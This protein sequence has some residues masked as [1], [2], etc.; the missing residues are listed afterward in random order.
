MKRGRPFE[1]GNKF[2][3]GRPPGSQNKK[4][5]VLQQLLDEHATALMKKGLVMAL[6]GE[7]PLLRIF[8]ERRLPRFQD[9]PINIGRLPMTTIDEVL[10]AHEILLKKLA[11]GELTPTQAQHFDSLLE[12]RRR[13]IETQ[14]LG[15]RVNALEAAPYLE[16]SK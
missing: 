1:P 14:D 9:A 8:L 5:L 4:T 2:G 7:V 12:S 10:R 15:K 11:A 16:G 6:Q 3:R 13:M